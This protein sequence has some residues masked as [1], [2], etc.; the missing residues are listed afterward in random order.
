MIKS[1]SISRINSSQH[2][3]SFISGAGSS[4]QGYEPSLKRQIFDR[5]DFDEENISFEEEIPEIAIA[6][7]IVNGEGNDDVQ[8][9]H[10][11]DGEKQE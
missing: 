2:N 7:K 6:P 3:S 9:K 8:D 10:A 1:V 4:M 11:S 5:M